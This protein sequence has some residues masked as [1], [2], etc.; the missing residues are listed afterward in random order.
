MHPKKTYSRVAVAILAG[1]ALS[2]V[3]AFAEETL[4][5]ETRRTVDG[6]TYT[7]TRYLD[8]RGAVRSEVRAQDGRLID[9]A[10]LSIAPPRLLSPALEK[11]LQGDARG[12][13][14]VDIALD[15]PLRRAPEATEV[16]EADV[17]EGEIAAGRING[18][19][20]GPAEMEERAR[21]NAERQ[22][23]A[24]RA[25]AEE[26]SR[27]MAAWAS[28]HRLDG[29]KGL[30]E[31]LARAGTRLTLHLDAMQIRELAASNDP[32]IAGIELHEPGEDDV[33]SAMNA[34]NVTNWALPYSTTRG[35]GIGIYMTESGCAAPS[36]ITNY[37]RLSGSETDHSRN[38]G[39]I[40]RAVSPASYL[41]CRGSA[42][43]PQIADLGGVGGNPPI[44]I[45]TRSNSSNN[46][47]A[48][49]TLDRDWDNFAYDYNIAI[50]NSGGNTGTGTGNV[51][52]PGKGL[53]VTTV[54][55]YSHYTGSIAASSPFVNPDIGNQKPEVVA[56]G[57]SITA[58]GFTMSGTS[59]STPHAAA[60]T[61]DMM[62]HTTA[63]QY[64][65]Y[66]AKANLLA[67]ATDPVGGG[68]NRVGHG[69]IDFLSAQWYGY[70]SWW[71]GGADSWNYFD[72]LD[73]SNDGIVTRK[74][75]IPASWQAV[76]ASLAWMNRGTH[77][78][79]NRNAPHAIGMDLGVLVYDPNGN[80]VGGSASWDNPYETVNFV[81]TVS[82]EYTFRIYRFSKR[83]AGAAIRMGLYVNYY[84]P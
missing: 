72:G 79:N 43:L 51:Q 20:L 71:S 21:A 33:N 83:D 58:G 69:G 55:N 2:S 80:Y 39:A 66:L 9:P 6:E 23:A 82:G 73:G 49:N 74:V 75:Y 42:V 3:S 67:G 14:E 47:T 22:L 52:S 46:T 59:M 34:T 31:S 16:G 40:I 4:L 81:P 27:R 62:S 70:W 17:R 48:Y 68:A 38:V 78:Y 11:W 56:P 63:L 37:T 32:A 19:E 53:N 45:V 54:G 7:F 28:R 35:A 64:R 13:V 44:H 30:D 26:R 1:L 65:P 15:M 76:R 50:F 77:T 25:L 57:T 8:E 61:A 5:A 18:R 84:T 36:R 10:R 24:N 29:A 41:Y 60:F 12:T